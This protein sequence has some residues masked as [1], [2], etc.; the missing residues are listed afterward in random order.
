MLFITTPKNSLLSP[1]AWQ[2]MMAA[3]FAEE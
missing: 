1:P 3:I 2:G